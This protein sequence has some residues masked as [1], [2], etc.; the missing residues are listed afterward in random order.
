MS[1]LR[2]SANNFREWVKARETPLARLIYAT[3][4]NLRCASVPVIPGV[5]IF[6]YHL[7]RQV[8]GAF[9]QFIQAVWYTPLFKARL[10]APAPRL[11]LYGG[12]PMVLGP[13]EITLGSDCRVAGV[14][15]MIGRATSKEPTRLIVGDNCDLGWA[16]AISVARTVRLGNN[17]RL[18]PGCILAGFPGHPI[19]AAARAAG[20]PDTEDQIG[21]IILE[22]DVWLGTRVMV[23]AG[24]TIG[25]GT[26][27]AQGSV[28]TKDLPPFVLAAGVPA[29]VKRQLEPSP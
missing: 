16:G 5:H 3:A 18:A 22:D 12:M 25:R 20:A 15:N 9:N 19:D 11:R 24:V 10:S 17:V 29:V 26:V 21:D 14:L 7:H 6:L 13:I 27:V 23:N 2:V 8:T 1:S 28:V 4:Y